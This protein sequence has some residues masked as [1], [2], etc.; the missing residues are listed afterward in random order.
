MKNDYSD[1]FDLLTEIDSHLIKEWPK[2]LPPDTDPK[3]WEEATRQEF[4]HRAILTEKIRLA[5]SS[6]P[7]SFSMLDP[8]EAWLYNCRMQYVTQ[9]VFEAA[10][11]QMTCS[12]SPSEFLMSVMVDHWHE[13]GA[14]AFW[15]HAMERGGKPH[16][17]VD[18]DI[19]KIM[20][21]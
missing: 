13:E 3:F 9:L 4:A 6:G 19:L 21:P 15:N 14:I 1:L 8:I 18:E 5:L 2:E 16:P 17:E 7:Q 20:T 12:D 11:Q 10:K